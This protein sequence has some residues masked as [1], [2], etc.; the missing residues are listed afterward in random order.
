MLWSQ[1]H[2]RNL[3]ASSD[4]SCVRVQVKGILPQLSKATRKEFKAQY[5]AYREVRRTFDIILLKPFINFF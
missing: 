4:A 2:G 3:G 5:K 1:R